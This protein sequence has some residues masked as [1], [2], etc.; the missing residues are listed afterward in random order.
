MDETSSNNT[1]LNKISSGHTCTACDFFFA[2]YRALEKHM[3]H[4]HHESECPFCNQIFPS[5]HDVRKHVNNCVKNGTNHESCTNCNQVFTKFGLRRHNERCK[6]RKDKTFTCKELCKKSWDLKKQM[7]EEHSEHLEV[8]R[9][10]CK[11]GF[12]L[13]W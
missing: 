8:S 2:S 10:V 9:K 7:K 12:L 3:D 11:Q 13:Q 1:I 6:S 5:R 4:K